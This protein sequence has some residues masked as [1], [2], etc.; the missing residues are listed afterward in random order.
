MGCRLGAGIGLQAVDGLRVS[1]FLLSVAIRQIE[2][3]ITMA[4]AMRL[5]DDHY[6]NE[7]TA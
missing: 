3:E 5:V 1:D 2:G 6:K 4:E 7:F